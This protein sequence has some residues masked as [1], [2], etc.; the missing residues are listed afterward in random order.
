[1]STRKEPRPVV[2][3]H[4]IFHD[5][6]G[7]AHDAVLTCVWDDK[8]LVNQPMVNLVYVSSDATK[9]DDYGRQI[10]RATSCYHGGTAG[11]C[12]GY[13]WRYQGEEPNPVRVPSSV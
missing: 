10:E 9:R 13:Y 8:D 7:V 11:A 4:V 2:G 12:Y 1:M 6:T 5:S 3:D